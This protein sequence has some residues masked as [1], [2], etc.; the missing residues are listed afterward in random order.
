MW[1]VIW[2]H[3][4][5]VRGS[6]MGTC[7]ELHESAKGGLGVQRRGHGDGTQKKYCDGDIW[8]VRWGHKGKG[9]STMYN[10]DIV[11]RVSR[12]WGHNG[13]VRSTMMGT[14]GKLYGDFKVRCTMMG[15]NNEELDGDTKEGKEHYD[16]DIMES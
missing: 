12:R 2:G 6:V 8:R 9:R 14:F 4:E 15:T 16:D 7:G 1:K 11:W 3:R 10:G 13:R 5:R